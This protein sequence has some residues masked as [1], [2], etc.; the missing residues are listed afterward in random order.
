MGRQ[1]LRIWVVTAGG[2]VVTDG[3]MACLRVLGLDLY[4]PADGRAFTLLAD[5]VFWVFGGLLAGLVNAALT[6]SWIEPATSSQRYRSSTFAIGLAAGILAIYAVDLMGWLAGLAAVVGFIV[7]VQIIDALPSR[8]LCGAA[9][10]LV[11]FAVQMFF[12]SQTYKILRAR[13][14]VYFVETSLARMNAR[15]EP[16]PKTIPELEKRLG[17]YAKL[18]GIRSIR[19]DP[20]RYDY[21]YA[22]GHNGGHTYLTWGADGLPGPSPAIDPGTP[23]ADIDGRAAGVARQD[24]GRSPYRIRITPASPQ[25]GKD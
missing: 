25:T 5:A 11:V 16:L 6:V 20:W 9:A 22:A 19:T 14:T 13:Q 24:Q 21:F 15:G 12:R 10:I 4:D 23:G 1:F 17:R 7:I 3:G 18:H 8:V 2:F